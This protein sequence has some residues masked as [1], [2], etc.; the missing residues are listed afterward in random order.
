ME[1]GVVGLFADHLGVVLGVLLGVISAIA[2]VRSI[3]KVSR[4]EKVS[5]LN[6]GVRNDLPDSITGRNRFGEDD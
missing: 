5:I 1:L 3:I 4:G 2:L 6:I